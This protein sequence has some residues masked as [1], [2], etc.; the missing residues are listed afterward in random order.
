M[1]TPMKIVLYV[2]LALVLL[3]ITYKLYRMYIRMDI[4][5]KGMDFIRGL[6]TS[7]IYYNRMLLDSR[8]LPTIGVGHLIRPDESFEGVDLMT[9]T[10]TNEQVDRLF[11]QDLKVFVDAANNA[12]TRPIGQNEFDA[13]ISI[14]Y[15]IGKGWGDG[16]GQEATFIQLIDSTGSISNTLNKSKEQIAMAIMKFHFPT[17][18]TER[19]AKEARLFVE[20][21]YNYGD[22]LTL[23]PYINM[24]V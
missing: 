13:V 19:R 6:E 7:G 10:L 18:L 22:E 1:S 8:G 14:L 9:G 12:I 17:N 11:H 20:G 15:N 23:Q 24:A 21:N 2:L 16:I 5:Q 4:S 3:I